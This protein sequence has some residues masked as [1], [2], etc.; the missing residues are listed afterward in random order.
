MARVIELKLDVRAGTALGGDVGS[1]N[2]SFGGSEGAENTADDKVTFEFAAVEM[3]A[4]LGCRCTPTAAGGAVRESDSLVRAGLPRSVWGLK[5]EVGKVASVGVRV[6]VL[7]EVIGV[8]KSPLDGSPMMS[9]YQSYEWKLKLGLE[10]GKSGSGSCGA[11]L[12]NLDRALSTGLASSP[13]DQS[14]LVDVVYDELCLSGKFANSYSELRLSA[15]NLPG[16]AIE[17]LLAPGG[18][19]SLNRYFG[20][21]S[22]GVALSRSGLT[23]RSN[24]S[25]SKIMLLLMLTLSAY[26]LGSVGGGGSGFSVDGGAGKVLD[27]IDSCSVFS[28]LGA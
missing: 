20:V 14:S 15:V 7:R 11:L 8:S 19:T 2:G 5:T 18:T 9:W 28:V 10:G 1:T 13:S 24:A 3:A 6:M 22:R 27:A 26:R 25:S 12:C 21:R 23:E 17:G 16:T 4:E